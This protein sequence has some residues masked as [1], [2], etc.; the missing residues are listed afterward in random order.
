MK[1]VFAIAIGGGNGLGLVRD[2]S[3]LAR[4][5]SD[6]S[7]SGANRNRGALTETGKAAGVRSVA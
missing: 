7:A 1:T 2:W 6:W 5:D 4:N 3:A